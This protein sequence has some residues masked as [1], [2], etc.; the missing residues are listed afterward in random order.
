MSNESLSSV[1]LGVNDACES[2]HT[3]VHSLPKADDSVAFNTKCLY[4]S[5]IDNHS[6]KEKKKKTRIDAVQKARA[7]KLNELAICDGHLANGKRNAVFVC[8]RT[9]ENN[10][11]L[12]FASITL[13]FFSSFFLLN[14]QKQKKE[15]N[16]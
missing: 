2:I 14:L 6:N 11:C 16:I 4:S 1:S 8:S 12:D 9:S 13:D 3:L 15:K 7:D 5:T 10:M